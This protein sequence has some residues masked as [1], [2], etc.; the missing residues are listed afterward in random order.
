M[1]ACRICGGAIARTL[2][3]REMMFGTR[4]RFAYELCGDCGCLQIAEVPRDVAR[5]YPADYYSFAQRPPAGLKRLRRRL[6]R[7]PILAAPALIAAALKRAFPR[8]ALLHLYRDIG[9]TVHDRILDVGTGSG[10]HVVALRDAGIT[11][12]VGLDPF[13]PHDIMDGDRVL[14]HRRDLADMTGEFDLVTFHHALEHVPDQVASLAQA[15]ARLAPQ[16]RVLVRVPCVSSWAFEHYGVDW[17]NLDAPRHCCLHSHESIR[18][19]AARA[20]L[21]VE[22]LWCDANAMSIMGS[23]QYRRDIPLTDPRSFA[24]TK[25]GSIFSA[26]ERAAFERQAAALNRELRGDWICVLLRAAP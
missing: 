1:S 22:R 2:D 18:R 14:V 4:E 5:H 16:G 3:V 9:I 15:R 8:D 24:R 26:A 10:E 17:V 13:V 25:S 11:G 23:E 12:A 19:A 20:G 7:R 21:E 6:K